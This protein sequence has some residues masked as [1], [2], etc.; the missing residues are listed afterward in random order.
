MS[1]CSWDG[2]KPINIDYYD[3]NLVETKNNETWVS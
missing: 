2:L 3:G 1:N